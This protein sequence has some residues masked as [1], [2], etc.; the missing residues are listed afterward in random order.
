M[1]DSSHLAHVRL[2]A[3]ALAYVGERADPNVTWLVELEAHTADEA[4]ATVW[5]MI[6]ENRVTRAHTRSSEGTPSG[7]LSIVV[8]PL[9]V[10]H[11]SAAQLHPA[12]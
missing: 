5:Q 3:Y 7:E 10:W 11:V 12:D 8:N 2:R 6:E 1:R 9:H 4:V